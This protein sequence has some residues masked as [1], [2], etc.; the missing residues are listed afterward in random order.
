MIAF[1]CE[2]CG[3]RNTFEA[4]TFDQLDT[5]F[6]CRFCNEMVP[7]PP[8]RDNR[9]GRD[10][11]N[12]KSLQILIVDDEE[13]HRDLA[14][15]MLE[16]EYTVITADDGRE[17]LQ[18]ASEANPDLILLD[19]MMPDMSGHDV[20]RQLK[21]DKRTRHIPVIFVTSLAES[22]EEKKGLETGA[23]DYITKPI[24]FEIA[25][26]RI[27]VHL[28][29]K[30]QFDRRKKEAQKFNQSIKWLEQEVMN[31][32]TAEM[33]AQQAISE[34]A[35]TLDAVDHIVTIQNLEKRIIRVNKAACQTFEKSADE[36]LGRYCHELFQGSP[37]PCRRCLENAEG[38]EATIQTLKVENKALK[39]TFLLN[40]LP[41]FDD[42]G[43]LTGFIHVAKEIVMPQMAASFLK[44]NAGQA[45]VCEMSQRANPNRAALDNLLT[46]MDTLSIIL[47]NNELIRAANPDDKDTS[48][49]TERISSAV[50]RA[51]VLVT[52]T[53]NA[54]VRPQAHSKEGRLEP[55]DD[56][57]EEYS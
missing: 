12:T 24:N 26:A 14:Q 29:M 53:I 48:T 31:H 21:T 37:T 8:L 55:M 38:V 20:C 11:V 56:A 36:L 7:L 10:A 49:K 22:D 52:E 16:V 19:I 17:A 5:H 23:V 30:R 6:Q 43:V 46:V 27:A 47:L 28:E 15:A 57:P 42:S 9:L 39:K 2:E 35:Q 25:K 18:L 51:S 1:F 41:R 32:Q 40:R 4:K 54:V 13:A 45:P 50:S 3:G 34:L 33:E 44:D